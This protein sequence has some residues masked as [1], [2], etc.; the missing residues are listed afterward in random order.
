MSRIG[1]MPIA[2]P[3][4]VQITEDDGRVTVTGPLGTLSRQI[5]PEMRLE[6]EDGQLLVRR[7]SDQPRHRALHGLT[8]TLVNNMVTGVT[9]GFQGPRA[10]RRRLSRHAR[11]REAGPG[12][13]LFAPG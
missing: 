10:E 2:V 3:D 9:T 7:P 4:G 13:R 8:R 1:K 6:R 11:R 5:H 12:A